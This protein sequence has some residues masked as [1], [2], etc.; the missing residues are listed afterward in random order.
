MIKIKAVEI[1]GPR[2]VTLVEDELAEPGA[3]EVAM[4][5]LYS[6]ISHGTEMNVYRGDAPMWQRKQD[7][8]RRLFVK[9]DEPE[10]EYP[11]PT[12]MLALV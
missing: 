2:Q 8:R 3:G 9:S 12:G 4:R 6:G 11:L 7:R 1:T 10:W 5:S